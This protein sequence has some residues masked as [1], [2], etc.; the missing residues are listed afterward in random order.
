MQECPFGLSFAKCQFSTLRMT[1]KVSRAKD[2]TRT[3]FCDA[4]VCALST[5]TVP[6]FRLIS[7]D[8]Y[9]LFLCCLNRH[10]PSVEGR[11]MKASLAA[12]E[13]VTIVG[14]V[15]MC[16]QQPSPSRSIQLHSVISS[17]RSSHS[18]SARSHRGILHS[19]CAHLRHGQCRIGSADR[20]P[21]AYHPALGHSLP[22][23]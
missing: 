14:V 16:H 11:G 21:Q 3:F 5:G 15:Q 13:S 6:W 1:R 17:T 22:R 4:S 8:K 12:I 23:P 19:D 18:L 9:P 7:T 2:V 20:L 10:V